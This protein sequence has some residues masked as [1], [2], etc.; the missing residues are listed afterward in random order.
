[1]LRHLINQSHLILGI[2]GLTFLAAN[3]ASAD[4][5]KV[6]PK[7][8]W[9][10]QLV[11]SFSYADQKFNSQGNSISLGES[12]SMSL[13]P[14]F[15]SMLKPQVKALTA[16][17]NTVQPGLSDSM[18]ITE[19]GVDIQSSVMANA[20]AL[21]YGVTDRLSVGFMLP[22]VYAS[23]DVKTK[24]SETEEYQ[25]FVS[26][27]P[28]GHPLRQ[29]LQA[30]QS[31][32]SVDGINQTLKAD[33]G[34]GAGMDSWSGAGIG[35]LEIGAKYKYFDAHP[36]RMTTK[37]GFRVPT[38]R[39]DNADL[40]FDLGFGDGQWDLAAFN[41]VDYSPFSNFY[42]T[43]EAGYTAQLPN[44]AT[45]RV[46]VVQGVEISPIKAKLNRDL[47][48]IV[49]TGLEANWNFTRLLSVSPKYRFRHKFSDDYSGAQGINTALL[50]AETS[51]TAHEGILTL[52]FSNL[53]RVRSG[54]SSLPVDAQLFY[55]QRFAGEN[56]A[57]SMT[58][59]VQLK[60]YF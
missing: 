12:Y 52:G 4:D 41:Y 26:K 29:G 45:Y 37:A 43:W 44:E 7:N 20:F 54:E 59:G 35:D 46:P 18:P 50:E 5:A 38:G 13:T 28:E 22:I 53:P 31:Q 36:V 49:E 42:L 19:L 60:A 34:Y 6:L 11:S 2:I 21:E 3:S 57:E 1:M 17:L 24:S 16:A 56:M 33:M 39:R 55:R 25:G 40:L 58:G 10:V 47:G 8:R 51:E 27:L 23:V 30:V 15:V 14:G 32:L 48:D 9:R